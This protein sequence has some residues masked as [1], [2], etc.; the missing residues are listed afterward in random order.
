MSDRSFGGSFMSVFMARVAIIVHDVDGPGEPQHI[1]QRR[2]GHQ[3]GVH[4]FATEPN[5]G[6]AGHRPD[7][8]G[9]EQHH[10]H[11]HVAEAEIGQRDPNHRR[12]S[13]QI[14]QRDRAFFVDR[15]VVHRWAA[16]HDMLSADAAAAGG[17]F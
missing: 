14:D 12:Q 15:D 6:K 2:H 10:R 13:N 5:V 3:N 8:A 9:D 4:L 1:N 16:Q 11:P 7:A 17:Q